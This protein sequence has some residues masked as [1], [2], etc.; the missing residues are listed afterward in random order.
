[1]GKTV[2]AE[3]KKRSEKGL[4]LAKQMLLAEKMDYPKLREALEHYIANWNDST[5]PGLFSMGC[6]AVG[7]NPE[8]ALPPQ[9]AIAMMAAAFDI[10]DDIIDESETK[11]KVPTVYG[12]FGTG[13][14]ILLGNAFLI[15]GFK[16]LVDSTAVLPKEK[17]KSGLEAYKNL[18]FEVGNAHALE[19]GLKGKKNVAASDYLK[20]IEMKAAGIEADIYLGALFGGGNDMEVEASARLGRIIGILVTLREEFIDVF[21]IEELCQRIAAQDLPVPLLFALQDQ[22]SENRIKEILLKPKITRKDI[23][24]LVDVTLEAGAVKKLKVEMKLLME[25]GTTLSNA[26]SPILRQKLQVL[27]QFM[28]EDL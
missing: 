19:V 12:K 26:L 17:G 28:L 9:A 13:I 25:E 22:I 16:L 8:Y 5:H 11:H 3:L 1:M 10:H 14:A 6:E 24:N 27:L 23:D 15:E 18:L 4:S 21:E 7:G 2:V 20:I